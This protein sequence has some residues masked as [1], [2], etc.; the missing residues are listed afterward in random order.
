MTDAADLTATEA[1][2]LIAR[3][4]LSPVELTEACIARLEAINPA[5]NAVVATDLAGMREAAKAAEDA[6]MKGG[7]LGAVHGLPFGVKDMIDVTGLPEMIQ[8]LQ[9][10]HSFSDISDEE[11]FSTG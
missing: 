2:R 6:V 3:R 7:A 4:Q 10:L 9:A 5:I 11:L 1:R 8:E